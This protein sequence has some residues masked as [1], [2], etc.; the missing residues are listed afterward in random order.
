MGDTIQTAGGDF[1]SS[2]AGGFLTVD[3]GAYID[4]AGGNA[5]F[6]HHGVV[7]LNGGL[8][9]GSG[10]LNLTLHLDATPTQRL[11]VNRLPLPNFGDATVT[12][13]MDGTSHAELVTGPLPQTLEDVIV[14]GAT[15]ASLPTIEI[16]DRALGDD[17]FSAAL[18]NDIDGTIDLLFA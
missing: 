14:L 10:L 6:D 17:A 12:L 13:D 8:K 7:Q 15:P 4:T 9:T 18:V 1:S 3:G 16:I 11:F 5:L 2:G